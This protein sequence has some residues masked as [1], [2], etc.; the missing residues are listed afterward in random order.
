MKVRKLAKRPRA[1]RNQASI[2]KRLLVECYLF[3]H[4]LTPSYRREVERFNEIKKLV[5]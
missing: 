3:F 1:E 2:G 4:H 5:T